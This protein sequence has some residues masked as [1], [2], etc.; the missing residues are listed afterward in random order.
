VSA[1]PVP[2]PSQ[3]SASAVAAAGPGG[4]WP[5]TGSNI[6]WI[7]GVGVLLVALGALGFRVLRPA[8][9]RVSA[10]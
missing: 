9:I 8:K 7:V 3:T 1:S 10:E 2:D 5:V 6:W 4:G